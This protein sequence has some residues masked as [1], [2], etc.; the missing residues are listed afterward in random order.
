MIVDKGNTLFSTIS[1]QNRDASK[2]KTSRAKNFLGSIG[3][4]LCLLLL[5][6]DKF[7]INRNKGSRT[8][9]L[10]GSQRLML[11]QTGV[12]VPNE[13]DETNVLSEKMEKIQTMILRC[14]D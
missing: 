5:H 9:Q 13:Y 4:I 14:L 8:R 3:P 10:F 7:C 12:S 1:P 2:A 6:L 11:D